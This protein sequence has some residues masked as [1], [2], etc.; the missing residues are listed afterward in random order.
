MDSFDLIPAQLYFSS[1][2]L[3]LSPCCYFNC[4][5]LSI[6]S[7]GFLIKTDLKETGVNA[8]EEIPL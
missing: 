1:R 3:F 6:K 5:A 7:L 8:R 4:A 2:P